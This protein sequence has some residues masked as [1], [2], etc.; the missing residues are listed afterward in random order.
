[1]KRR[2]PDGLRRESEGVELTSL[3]PGT[4]RQLAL[5]LSKDVIEVAAGDTVPLAAERA[6]VTS[7][8]PLPS[9]YRMSDRVA[10]SVGN[11]GTAR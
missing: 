6:A 10:V 9:A 11:W 8:P 2:S 3:A 5:H 1:M 4:W 7:D